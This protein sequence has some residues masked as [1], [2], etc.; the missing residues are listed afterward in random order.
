ML[1]PSRIAEPKDRAMKEQPAS[2]RA[3]YIEE[4]AECLFQTAVLCEQAET[5]WASVDWDDLST[6]TK[7]KYRFEATAAL[8]RLNLARK[9]EAELRAREQVA[10]AHYGKAFH[11]LSGQQQREIVFRNRTAIETFDRVLEGCFQPLDATVARTLEPASDE[12]ELAS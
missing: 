6:S 7:S 10:D 2:K 8:N 5:L 12:P 9:Y 1:S 4:L 11:L 3:V